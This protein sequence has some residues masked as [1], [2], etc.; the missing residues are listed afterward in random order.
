[1]GEH[2]LDLLAY[3]NAKGLLTVAS[4]TFNQPGETE[5]SAAESL[6]ALA[7]FV[8]AAPNASVSVQAQSWAFLPAGEPVGRQRLGRE[9]EGVA[10]SESDIAV[11]EV[12]AERSHG[13][14]AAAVASCEFVVTAA[15]VWIRMVCGGM[16]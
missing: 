14:F 2:A 1:M 11:S 12:D 10:Q 3:A 13:I 9:P 4:F 8:D 5:A 6:A 16:T 7:G 15:G